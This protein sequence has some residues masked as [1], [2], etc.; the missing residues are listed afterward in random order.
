MEF[1]TEPTEA[2]RAEVERG[3]DEYNAGFASARAATPVRGVFV[4]AGRVV[5]GLDAS[6][7]WGKLHIRVLWVHPDFRSRGLGRRLVAW[8]E[9]RGRELGCVAAVVN[10]MSFQA[11]DLY[12]RLGYVEV[13][14]SEGYAGG[15]RRH[16]FEKWL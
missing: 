3:L 14:V 5:A 13:T 15:A 4:D 8:A 7:Y 2:Q 10:T 16:Y 11:P 6:A 9:E 12:R 1:L